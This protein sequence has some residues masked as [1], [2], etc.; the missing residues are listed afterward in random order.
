MKQKND[1]P[2][3]LQHTEADDAIDTTQHKFGLYVE[4]NWDEKRMK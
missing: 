4:R 3:I 2:T 1:R